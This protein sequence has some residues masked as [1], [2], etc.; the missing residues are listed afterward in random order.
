LLNKQTLNKL[1]NLPLKKP[2][3]LYI[4]G[5]INLLA[6]TLKNRSAYNEQQ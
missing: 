1:K 3:K 2:K 4:F 6:A 5:D